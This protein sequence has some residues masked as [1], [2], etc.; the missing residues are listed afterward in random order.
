[1]PNVR[2]AKL[3]ET[4]LRASCGMAVLWE[5]CPARESTQTTQSTRVRRDR[6]ARPHM[7]RRGRSGLGWSGLPTGQTAPGAGQ[8]ARCGAGLDEN[9]ADGERRV[10]VVRSAGGSAAQRGGQHV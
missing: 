6:A 10:V 7:D 9:G 4:E 1:M 3:R 8:T 2:K 5:Y